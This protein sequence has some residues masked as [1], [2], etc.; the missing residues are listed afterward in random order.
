MKQFSLHLPYGIR[1]E[2]IKKVRELDL[3]GLAGLIKVCGFLL[4][5][6]VYLFWTAH[7]N[8]R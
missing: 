7:P 1:E 2:Y 3:E 6:K 4:Q 5:T 8:P